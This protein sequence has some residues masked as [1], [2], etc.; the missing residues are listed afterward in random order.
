MRIV[1]C[2]NMCVIAQTSVH[3]SYCCYCCVILDPSCW[4]IYKYSS[5]IIQ[6]LTFNTIHV[7]RDAYACPGLSSAK[8]IPYFWVL[9]HQ[10]AVSPGCAAS[11]LTSVS[12]RDCCTPRPNAGARHYAL[13]LSTQAQYRNL[14][15]DC[16][17]TRHPLPANQSRRLRLRR[18]ELATMPT[19]PARI[20]ARR[21]PTTLPLPRELDTRA[22]ALPAQQPAR[23]APERR[24]R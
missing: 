19:H 5:S 4:S 3:V 23:G 14:L 2:T 24:C 9:V 10:T 6:E 21:P 16:G 13:A 20:S 7:I 15:Q 11:R 18:S 22:A 8:N 1:S 17:V 12:S